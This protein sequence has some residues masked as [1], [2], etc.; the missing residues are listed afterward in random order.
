M[1][2]N[3]IVFFKFK[4][5]AKPSEV[6]SHMEMFAAL[7]K[8]IPGILSYSAGKT[9]RVDYEA[10]GDYDCMHCLK[11]ESEQALENYFHHEAHRNFISQNQHIWQDV[12]VVNTKED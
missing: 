5:T 9:F 3:H 11:C 12:L 8:T 4:E 10:T 1:V 6:D 2:V 7:A